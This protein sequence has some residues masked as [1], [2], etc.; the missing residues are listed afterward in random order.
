[1]SLHTM[2]NSRRGLPRS[3]SRWPKAMTPDGVVNRFPGA[4]IWAIGLILLLAAIVV[5]AV[6]SGD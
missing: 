4:M 3:S 6:M 2:A 5:I 1:M